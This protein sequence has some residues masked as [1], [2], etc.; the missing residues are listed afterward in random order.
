M[1]RCYLS[2]HDLM[3]STRCVTMIANSIVINFVWSQ[4]STQFNRLYNFEDSVARSA[5]FDGRARQ[6]FLSL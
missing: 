2:G 5:R 6:I 1:V 3:L 4:N